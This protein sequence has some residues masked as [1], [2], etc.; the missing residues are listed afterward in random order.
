MIWKTNNQYFS[1]IKQT[2]IIKLETIFANHNYDFY[3][4]KNI[5]NSIARPL[6]TTQSDSSEHSYTQQTN[7]NPKTQP[8]SFT[9]KKK[10]K[11]IALRFLH[12]LN[13]TKTTHIK[14]N[15][16]K[17]TIKFRRRKLLP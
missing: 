16:I 1:I 3:T 17:R 12:F 6:L 11:Q 5:S 8:V 14:D 4:N 7:K 10:L 13:K 15:S 2:K 9:E